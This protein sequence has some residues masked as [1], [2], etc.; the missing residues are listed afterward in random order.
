[1]L[2]ERGDWSGLVAQLLEGHYDPAY[3]RSLPR[4]YKGA[5]D[6]A[7][8]EVRDISPEGFDALARVALKDHG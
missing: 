5:Q 7:A 3:L 8:L 2:A 4:N 6:A 1:M